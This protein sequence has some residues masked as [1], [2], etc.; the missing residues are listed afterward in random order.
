MRPFT[1]W[2]LKQKLTFII[3]V[4]TTSALLLAG[5]GIIASD[6]FLFYGYLQRDLTA[7]SRIIADNTTAALSFDDPESASETLAALRARPH[8]VTACVYRADNTV[9]A[10]YVRTG[11]T[12]ECPAAI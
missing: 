6:S 5:L 2:P 8:L 7:L 1:H 12:A 10:S 4:T 11:A 9:L 3:M